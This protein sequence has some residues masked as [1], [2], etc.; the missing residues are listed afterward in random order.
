M[1]LSELVVRFRILS[2]LLAGLLLVSPVTSPSAFAAGP[3]SVADLAESLLGAVVNISTRPRIEVQGRG[4][5]F[6]GTPFAD[7]FNRRNPGRDQNPKHR[8]I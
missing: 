5:P 8:P 4:N 2:V 7:L 3:A 1:P 6:A